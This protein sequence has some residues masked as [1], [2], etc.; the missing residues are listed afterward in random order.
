MMHKIY[1]NIG[2]TIFIPSGGPHALGGGY[3]VIE[4]QEPTDFTMR[5][6]RQ[7]LDCVK[8]SE[9]MI[10]NGLDIE[11]ML[12]CFDYGGLN[13]KIINCYPLTV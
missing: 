6:E 7:R 1:V 8:L 4:I 11:K 10:H 5:V 13:L 2:D 9:N 12:D 3:L